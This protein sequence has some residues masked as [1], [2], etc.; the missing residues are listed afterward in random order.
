MS[1]LIVKQVENEA[2]YLA[3]RA[4]A[5][6]VFN[7]GGQPDPQAWE[8]RARRFLSQPGYD[9]RWHSIGL[10]DG[11]TV[12]HVVAK[13]YTLRYGRVE[14]R[15]GGVGA[16]C[17]DPDYR[18]QGIAAAVMR[19]SLAYMTGRGDHLSLL[20][21]VPVYYERFGYHTV[22]PEYAL[23]FQAADA[24]ALQASLPVRPV[25]LADLPQIAALYDRQWGQRIAM[26]R[27]PEL[28]RWRFE[29]FPPDSFCLVEDSSG[30]VVGYA[31]GFWKGYEVVAET[32]AAALSLAVHSAGEMLHKEQSEVDWG[33][34][35]DDRVVY[36]LRNWI[37][38]TLKINFHTGAHWMARIVDAEALRSALLPE[39]NEQAGIDLRGLI[40]DIQPDAVYVGL[41]GQDTTNVQL[42]HGAFLQVLFG[43]LPPHMLDV[44]P[45]A[46]QLLGRLFPPRVAMIAP[47]DYF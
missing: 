12:G 30:H 44:H 28:W 18:Q 16:V 10:I 26:P 2:E 36:D 7:R 27:T 33:V 22:W 13:P 20:R 3:G 6:R 4:L 24:A 46:A 29:T 8:E 25:T 42:G 43:S 32:A 34:P 40:F 21:A 11:K 39:I 1:D 35:P 9:V 15:V 41:R 5:S 14:L 17:T 47:W 38:T 31:A 37:P 45:D 23:T 19:E